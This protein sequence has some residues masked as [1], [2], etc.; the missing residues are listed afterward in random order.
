M[1][2]TLKINSVDCSSSVDWTSLQWTTVLTKEVDRLDFV[3]KKTG[4]KTIPVANDVVELLEDGIKLFGGL[5]VEKNEKMVGGVLIGYDIKCKDY[6][7]KLDGKLVVKNYSSWNGDDIFKSIISTYTTGFTT[8]NVKQCDVSLKSIK[9]NYEQVSRALT[10]LC[11]QIGWDWY[12][13]PD[14]DLHFFDEEM[15]LAPFNLSDTNDKYEFQ[16]LEINESVV[17]LKNHVFVRGGEYKST[18]AEASAVDVYKGNS[19]QTTFPLAYKYDDITVTVN[20]VVQTIG[21]DQQTDPVTVDCLYNFDEKFV[22]FTVA[23]GAYTVKIFGDAYIPIIAAVRDQASITAYGEYQQAIVDKSIESIEEAQGRARSELKKY[24]ESVHEGR[25]KTIQTGLRV[26][27]KIN[28][29][30]TIRN[31]D[32]DFKIIRIVG[33]ARGSDHLEYDV[34]LLASGQVTFTDIMVNLINADKKN[35]TIASNEVLQRLELF[36]ETITFP[37]EIVTATKKSPPYTWGIGGSNDLKWGFGT[38]S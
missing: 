26:G 29:K 23:P 38:W 33:R 30:S 11:D 1:A 12:V 17:N 19:T 28:V 2:I 36:D 21:T 22:K 9:F 5:V 24:A 37:A 15:S 27:Q 10:Q 31:I 7:H 4:T 25:F 20:G 18:I 13:D 6:S 14:K 35:I 3:V 16:T 34:S 32:R 8:I